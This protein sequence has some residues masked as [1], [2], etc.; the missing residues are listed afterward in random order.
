M[1]ASIDAPWF[2]QQ[3]GRAGLALLDVLAKYRRGPT[4]RHA[5]MLK[6]YYLIERF[7]GSESMKGRPCK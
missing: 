1:K 4:L 7:G 2:W 6:M 5:K 3:Y